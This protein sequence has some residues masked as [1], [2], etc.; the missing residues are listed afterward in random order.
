MLF[1]KAHYNYSICQLWI[2]SNNIFMV[3]LVLSRKSCETSKKIGWTCYNTALS[4]WSSAQ[5]GALKL[6]NL[7]A[8]FYFTKRMLKG[9]D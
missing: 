7:R 3:S 5:A 6:L 9:V 1:E 2:D 8:G 4:S